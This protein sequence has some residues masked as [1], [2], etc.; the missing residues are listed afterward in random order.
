MDID[1]DKKVPLDAS[2]N[3]HSVSAV[4]EQFLDIVSEK[5]EASTS[6][7]GQTI[8]KGSVPAEVGPALDAAEAGLAALPKEK[9]GQL[10]DE[11]AKAVGGLGPSLQRLVDSTQ[12]WPVT[13]RT[14]C[15]R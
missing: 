9:I 8:T 7:R 6:A 12:H 2:A 4:G 3:V 5:D 13:S 14:T 10:L 15:P 11:T 1:N